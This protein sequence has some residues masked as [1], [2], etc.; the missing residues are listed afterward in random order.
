MLQ[1]SG[2]FLLIKNK[3]A[4]SPAQNTKNQIEH[5]EGTE[6]NKGTEVEGAESVPNG[7]ESLKNVS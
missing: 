2:V 6:N 4:P 7:I 3:I 1:I 5:E